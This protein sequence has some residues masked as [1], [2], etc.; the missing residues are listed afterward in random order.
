MPH[1]HRSKASRD[2]RFLAF[3]LLVMMTGFLVSDA[4][5]EDLRPSI[6]GLPLSRFYSFEDIGDVFRGARLSFDS[7]DR[8]AV[9]QDGAYFVLNDEAWIDRSEDATRS[10]RI[11][12]V[13]RDSDGTVFYGARGSWGVLSET[14]EGLLRPSS[15]APRDLP[16]WVLRT[17]FTE[18]LPNSSVVCFAGRTGIV[19]WNRDS[20]ESSFI[21]LAGVVH[22]FEMDGNVYAS[23][24]DQGVFRIE[25]QLGTA[26]PTEDH[27]FASSVVD[28]LATLPS[29]R[30]VASTFA[31]ELFAWDGTHLIPFCGALGARLGGRVSAMQA[32]PE[33]L[34]ALAIAG[35]GLYIVRLDGEIV[36][37][38]THPE[39]RLISSLANNEPGVL[40]AATESGVAKILYG[41]PATS[42]GQALGLPVGWPQFVPW[43]DQTIIASNGRVYEPV[44]VAAGE[45]ARFQLM[46]PQPRSGAWGIAAH[47]P[48]LLLGNSEGVFAR[49][50]GT[51]FQLVLG[52]MAV[53]RLQML[54]SGECLV[55]GE[56]EITALRLDSQQ[57]RECVPR[58]PGLG[59]PA[60]VHASRRAAWV[61]LGADHTARIILRDGRIQSRL[62]DSFPWSEPRWVSVSILEDLV[63]L[64]GDESARIYFDE[65]TEQLIEAPEVEA[66]L[67]RMP[68]WPSRI[69]PDSTGLWWIAHPHGVF[70]CD[71]TQPGVLGID[72]V[73]Y[74]AIHEH[75]PLLRITPGRQ[76]W[77]SNGR[78]L[79][80]LE[81]AERD[82]NPKRL[83]PRIVSAVDLRTNRELV[84]EF[85][86][87]GEPTH[88]DY[89]E[90]SIGLR[91]FAG[92]YASRPT[93]DYEYRI[94]DA[95]W[96]RLGK[97]SVL[98]LSN[99]REGDYRLET[100]LV[101]T[102]GPL[103]EPMTIAFIVAPPWF[104]THYAY[105]TYALLVGALV[106]GLVKFASRRAQARNL[107]LEKLV[108][109]RTGEL[110]ATMTKLEREV[111]TTATLAERNRMA[112]E[113]HDG[114]EQ[115]FAGLSMQ[116][117]A[118]CEFASCSPDVR[119]E[120]TVALNMLSYS[121]NEMRHVVR[122]LYSPLL[123]TVDLEAAL[124][125]IVARIA[126]GLAT[127]TRLG[128]PVQLGTSVEHHLLRIA[129]EA[130]A[131][132]VKHA[133]PKR[134]D[135]H[136]RYGEHDV[137]LEIRDDGCGFDPAAVLS[138]D[139][140][141]FGLPSFRGRAEKIGGTVK[142]VSRPG[143][144]T[145]IT[146][147]VP[148]AVS[149]PGTTL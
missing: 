148:F 38:L 76:V 55:L 75:S 10:I 91:F 21:Q 70:T 83:A 111:E 22:L 120:L 57:W 133:S 9:V 63:I 149:Q 79:L 64:S 112:G 26:E 105:G 78:T 68:Y 60:V 128:T 7:S 12:Q 35:M 86:R 97:T 119:R 99:L 122:N 48:W 139:F 31:R 87:Q 36:T 15:F 146:V 144:G 20:R 92:T 104:R 19:C 30:V 135:V 116:L 89:S 98:R 109:E 90:N 27:P 24:F 71:P 49:Q 1:R 140:G 102:R 41:V 67:R 77:A 23:T 34:V 53:A 39:Y 28:H 56:Q 61:E 52:D 142:I 100:R 108:A 8:L 114:V 107:A 129:Q 13:E 37:A 25:P 113:I 2:V 84:H 74:R 115:G 88:L 66:L 6:K 138:G 32:L 33:D 118:I 145:S 16:G 94:N 126:P 46:D 127:I 80:L 131:N 117:E 106:A 124:Q 4:Q 5:T 141:H 62:F 125:Q 134:V 147:Q 136:L 45:P 95:P 101:D 72:T 81:P 17:S 65:S 85:I 103:G 43:G 137:H 40:W 47:G 42:F 58:I 73:S 18:I 132:A 11:E 82:E 96:S 121:R 130:V 44:P 110:R 93:P 3:L 59:Y 50:P 51:P 54:E 14:S 69:Q 123:D 143:A 29:G